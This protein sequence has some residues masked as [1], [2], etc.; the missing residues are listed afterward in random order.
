[1]E[2]CL[3]MKPDRI[4]LAELRGDEAFYFIR[5]CASGHPGSITSCHAGSTAQTWDQLALMVKASGEGSGLEFSVIKRLL[6][7]AIDI[8]VH[9]KAHAGRRYITGIDFDPERR[10]EGLAP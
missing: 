5:N 2:A 3:R 9:I 6:K 7:L 8:V 10:V 4:I 1:M